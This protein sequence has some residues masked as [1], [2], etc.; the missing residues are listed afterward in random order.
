MIP[1][2]PEFKV[3]D[4]SDRES[5]EVHTHRYPPY[6]DF[7]F[8]S[9]WAWDTSGKRMISELNHNLV[10]RFTDYSTG[11]TFLSF[12]GE[13]E[14]ERTARVLIDYCK[15]ERFPTTL[16]LM[17]EISIKDIR[18]SV[19]RVEEDRDNFDYLYKVSEHARFLGGDFKRSRNFVNTFTREYPSARAEVADLADRGVQHSLVGVIRTWES[20]KIGANKTYELAHEE[21]AVGRLFETAGT[22]KLVVTAVFEGNAVRA[23]SIDEVL[24]DQYGI[25]HFQ[26]G[27][28]RYKG[29][30]DFLI[31]EK[32]KHLEVLG[33]VYINFEQDLG[34]EGLRRSK[35]AYRPMEFLKK[36]KV[37]LS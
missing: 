23:F 15:T 30:Y 25:S 19:L 7:N 20:N 35:L 26:K 31:Q 8:T 28:V 36:Y 24:Q 1:Q 4:V 17:P 27:D 21:A 16:K 13:V 29:I 10:V 9:L 5:V 11:E 2:F 37:S 22:H 14:T 33:V 12:L 32:S 34:V 18:S 6:S 3:V